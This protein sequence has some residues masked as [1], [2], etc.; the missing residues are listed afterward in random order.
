MKRTS[1]LTLLVLAVVGAAVGYVI[2]QVLTASARPTFTPSPLL[3]VMLFLL[4]AGVLAAAWPV[5]R[6][7]REGTRIDPIRAARTAMLARATS[8][9]GA[10]VGGFGAGLALFILTRPV[11][12]QVGSITVMIAVVV[13]AALLIA[14]ALVAEHFCTLP[15]D[16]D[17][18][19]PDASVP[20]PGP[21]H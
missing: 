4:G 17:D 5:R 12:P 20:G 7:V 13:T 14:A 16:P 8:L 9:L 1:P 11:A 2:D 19:Q 3:P 18:R 6:S 21:A 15:K 10:I